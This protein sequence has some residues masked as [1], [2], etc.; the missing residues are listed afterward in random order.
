MGGTVYFTVTCDGV[1]IGATELEG[2]GVRAG[3]LA[4]LPSYAAFGLSG[5]ARRLGV[6]FLAVHW[7]RVPGPAAARA[8]DA[9]SA[10]MS[11][12]EMRLGLLDAS[13]VAVPSPRIVLVDLPRR[14][15]MAGTYV[16]ADLGEA[17]A[18]RG[19]L[20]PSSPTRGTDASRPAAA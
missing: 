20:R 7:S 5:P 19:A 9:A 4:V 17:G 8:W 1:P 14:S 3:R 11:A 18:A 15:P 12:L 13:G 6:A 10:G 16:M 2:W